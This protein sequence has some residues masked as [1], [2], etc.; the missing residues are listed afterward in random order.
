MLHPPFAL[1]AHLDADTLLSM[2]QDDTIFDVGVHKGED[3]DFYL[4][5]GF[6]VI[7]FEADPVLADILRET[8]RDA[9]DAG[10][11]TLL[12]GAVTDATGDVTFYRNEEKT[13]FGTLNPDWRR[14][15][16]LIGR[17]QEA[18]I[19]RTTDFADALSRFGAPHY[20]K[21]DIEGSDHLCLEALRD[22]DAVPDYVSI[23]SEKVNW[24]A[25]QAEV[26]LLQSLGYTRFKAVQQRFIHRKPVRVRARDG[27]VFTHRFQAGASGPFGE[28]T[29]GRWLSADDLLSRYARIFQEYQR[30]GD[31][32]L[33]KRNKLMKAGL[34]AA[35]IVLSKSFPGWYDTHAAL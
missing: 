33:W 22:V 19:V 28:D 16:A 34:D 21:I 13:Q 3:T 32:S 11:F 23:E 9:I 18:V 17:D 27:R 35:E 20:L 1:S 12:E 29:T 15:N 8:F 25:L 7:G 24:Q 5:K 6:K 31:N 14:R 4:K 30:W 10:Q 26:A 2:K